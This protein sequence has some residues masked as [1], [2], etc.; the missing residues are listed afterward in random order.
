MD[1]GR[2]RVWRQNSGLSTAINLTKQDFAKFLVNSM[3]TYK[4]WVQVSERFFEQPILN[5][6]YEY[7]SRHWELDEHG[8][9]TQRIL[10]GRR[11]VQLLTPIPKPK[12]QRGPRQQQRMI[13]DEGLGLSTEEQEYD[14]T[15]IINE[16]RHH[17]DRWREIKEPNAWRVTPTTARL[18]QHWRHYDFPG[19]RPFFC[20]IEAVETVI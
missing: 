20:Q 15:P 16:L 17:V 5:S 19:I 2:R 1:L 10:D 4:G 9:P 13:F 7:P 8:Q 18:L 3:L 11:P 12:Q 14:P 6:P